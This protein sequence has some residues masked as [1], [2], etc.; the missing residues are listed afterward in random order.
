VFLIL[1]KL[2][3]GY[4]TI[5]VDKYMEIEYYTSDMEPMLQGYCQLTC[6]ILLQAV[7]DWRSYG[8]K[9]KSRDRHVRQFLKEKGFS[10]LREELLVFFRSRECEGL[11]AYID[12]NYEEMLKKLCIWKEVRGDAIHVATRES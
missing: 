10:S 6:A 3:R 12:L 8:G 5:R 4:Q 2:L 9:K 1:Q 7:E 11:C